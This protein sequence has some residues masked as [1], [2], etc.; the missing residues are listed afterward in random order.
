MHRLAKIFRERVKRIPIMVDPASCDR[1][2]RV[3]VNRVCA[4]PAQESCEVVFID[5][6]WEFDDELGLHRFAGD[7]RAKLACR[8]HG[9]ALRDQRK[10]PDEHK[11]KTLI[12]PTPCMGPN[13]RNGVFS[14]IYGKDVWLEEFVEFASGLPEKPVLVLVLEP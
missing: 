9:K 1:S 11:G 12:L 5:L 4:H 8:S 14:L 10:V 13:G 2:G 3:C 7:L 6:S